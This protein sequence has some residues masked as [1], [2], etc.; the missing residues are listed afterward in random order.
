MSI[1]RVQLVLSW[2][3]LALALAGCRPFVPAT[4]PGFVELEG[5]YDASEYRATTADGVV[6]GV[7]AFE[8][9]PKGELAFWVRALENRMRDSGG[10]ALLE[11]RAVKNRG[12]LTGTELRFG[13]DEGDE[14]YLYRLTVFVTEQR[15]F[16]LEAG[17]PRAQMERLSEQVDWSVTNFLQR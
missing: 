2:L 16:L 14:P 15:V 13:H 12:G 1:R 6:L 11:K 5:R 10:Y 17:G 3:T 9:D 4:P 7:R 8:N